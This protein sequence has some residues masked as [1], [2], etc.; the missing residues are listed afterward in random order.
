VRQNRAITALALGESGEQ[1]CDPTGR[2]GER[3]AESWDLWPLAVV[4]Y[5]MLAGAHP[6]AAATSLDVYDAVRTGRMTL[7]GTHLPDA[8]PS[9]QHFF[10]RAL[11][12]RIESRPASAL[13]LFS[14]FNQSILQFP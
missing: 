3:P 12:L 5:E 6:F 4:G 8:P 14:D 1:L 7:L 2:V 9:W 13:Q 11:A 10:D